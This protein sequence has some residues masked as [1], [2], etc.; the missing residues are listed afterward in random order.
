MIRIWVASSVSKTADVQRVW[1]SLAS[2]P[3]AFGSESTKNLSN[4]V[5][6]KTANLTYPQPVQTW[7]LNGLDT[8]TVITKNSACLS[9]GAAASLLSG[10]GKGEQD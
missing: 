1:A 3:P 7:S 10:E 9:L 2:G 4:L 6:G 8:T 5:S